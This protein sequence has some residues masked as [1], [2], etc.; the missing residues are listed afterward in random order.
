MNDDRLLKVIMIGM[1]DGNNR[2]GRPRKSWI[3][4]IKEW[5]GMSL[6]HMMDIVHDRNRWK[7]VMNCSQ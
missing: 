4:D 3:D 1:V 7:A 6:H 2:R 5:T